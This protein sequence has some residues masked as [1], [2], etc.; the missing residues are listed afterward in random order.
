MNTALKQFS[1]E[2]KIEIVLSHIENVQ[3]NCYKLGIKLIREGKIKLGRTLI[4]NG[5]IH[6]NSKFKG[7]EFEHLFSGDEL[8]LDAVKHHNST[9]LHHPEYWDSI[10]DMPEVYVAEM[11]C[12]CAARSAEFGSDVRE[13]LENVATVKYDFAMTDDI[14]KMINK[15][16]NMLLE[17]PF[18]KL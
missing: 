18:S 11:V 12:D 1:T 8:L 3:R 6:D 7:V 17:K 14:G 16:L 10:H 2:E 5:Q 9:N 15:Y 13:W 4:A